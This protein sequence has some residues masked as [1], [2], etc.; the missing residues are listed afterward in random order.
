MPFYS[1]PVGRKSG[2]FLNWTDCERSV[3][4]FAGAIFRRWSSLPEATEH[5]NSHGVT[6]ESISIHTCD[7]T[8][9]LLAYCEEQGIAPPSE[10]GYKRREEF[11]LGHGLFVKVDKNSGVDIFQKDYESQERKNGMFLSYDDWV[12][13]MRLADVMLTGLRKVKTGGEVKLFEHLSK[14]IY[15]SVGS[16]YPVL[17]IRKWFEKKGQMHPKKEGITLR[18][19]ELEHI[20]NINS[21]IT[22]SYCM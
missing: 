3:D 8:Q 14:S 19:C 9:T 1:V 11:Y 6:H 20:M 5:M 10:I 7:G 22:L 18:E 21:L 2:I 4:D 15:L 16:P 17:H 13:F 12:A